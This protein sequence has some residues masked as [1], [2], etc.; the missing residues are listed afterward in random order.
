MAAALSPLAAE[1]RRHDRDRFVTALFA[2]SERREALFALYAFNG[3]IARIRESVSEPLLG[4]MRL[5]WWRDAVEMIYAGG[6][7]AHPAFRGLAAAVRELG[8]ERAPLDR[9][10]DARSADLVNGPPDTLATLEAYAAGT[11]SSLIELALGALGA[12]GDAAK[13]VAH[14]AG[15]GW[16]LAGL[17]R[18]VPF[19]AGSGRLFLP[20]DLLEKEGLRPEDVPDLLKH[21][22]SSLPR[23]RESSAPLDSRLRGNDGKLSRVATTLAARA[24]EHLAIARAGRSDIPRAARSALLT[25]A[26]A[27]TYL[28]RLARARYDLF[29]PRWAVTRPAVLRLT[30]LA[31]LGRY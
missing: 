24:R 7:R 19:H 10:I 16:A 1:V 5:Q 17:M 22:S 25:T 9:L 21:H 18:A 29:D 6:D 13:R 12:R 23:K 14:H 30:I 8:L 31:A 28:R 2:P 15:I 20:R 3:E 26:L 27:E 4:E 11:A